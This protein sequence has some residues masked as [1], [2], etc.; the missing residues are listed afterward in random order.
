MNK[1]YIC[2]TYHPAGNKSLEGFSK[3]FVISFYNFSKNERGVAIRPNCD[4][5][6]FRLGKIKIK[7]IDFAITNTFPIGLYIWKK[8]PHEVITEDYVFAFPYL[9]ICKL[10]GTKIIFYNSNTSPIA[11]RI[12]NKIVHYCK[13][14]ILGFFDEYWHG[15]EGGEKFIQ[16]YL[17]VETKF[18]PWVRLE[19]RQIKT[20]KS[21]KLTGIFVGEFSDRKRIKYIIS[22]AQNAE[23]ISKSHLRI[24]LIGAKP[25]SPYYQHSRKMVSHTEAIQKIEKSHFLL[26]LS[27]REATGS[28]VLEA[29]QCGLFLVLSK[30]VGANE[31]VRKEAS[32]AKLPAGILYFNRLGCIVDTN[33]VT[34]AKL[35]NFLITNDDLIRENRHIRQGIVNEYLI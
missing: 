33:I 28:V 32:L 3:S 14:I 24:D 27:A 7:K 19:K 5:L 25:E 23:E 8:R 10:L 11:T 31:I 34:P 13:R 15:F 18:V 29:M 21:K 16:K 12:N 30:E 9:I 1:L 35:N 2:P 6:D 17:D 26:L 22:K 20:P 4:I